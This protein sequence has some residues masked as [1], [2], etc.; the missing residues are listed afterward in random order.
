MKERKENTEKEVW[1]TP[2]LTGQELGPWDTKGHLE[3]SVESATVTFSI[4]WK[5]K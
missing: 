4:R 5:L 2:H 1:E 3:Q